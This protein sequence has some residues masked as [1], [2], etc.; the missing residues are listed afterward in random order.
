MISRCSA[1]IAFASGTASSSFSTRMIAPKSFHE[2]RAISARG[3]VFK[4]RL[5]RALDLVGQRAHRR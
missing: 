3:R 1:A 2:A 5:H 4:L